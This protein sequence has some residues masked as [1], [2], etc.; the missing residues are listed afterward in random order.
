MGNPTRQSASS[1]AVMIA[2]ILT[3]GLASAQ[4]KKLTLE[5]LI[6]Q[7]LESIGSAQARGFLKN[8]VLTGSVKLVSRVG[9]AG[10]LKGD[11]AFAFSGVKLRYSM[12]FPA[13][14]YPGEQLGFDGSKVLTGFLP[15]G[16]RSG[17]SLYLEQQNTPMRDGL[18]GGTLSTGWTMLRLDQLKPRLEYKGLKKIDGRQL[19]EVSYRSQKG[20][21][22]LKIALFFE[23]TTFRHV[24]TE[25]EFKVPPRLGSGPNQSTRFQEDYYKLVEDFDDFLAADGLMVPRTYR[26]QLQVQTSVGSNLFDWNVVIEQVL[27][28]QALDDQIFSK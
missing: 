27:H 23:A 11:A 5:E 8:R 16:R 9:E 26:L 6:A 1:F 2:L 20:S 10:V 19:H 14:Q 25:Y 18:L 28:N 7:H 21:A 3:S 15:G 17:L 13:P 24:R 12:R 4:E 22:D